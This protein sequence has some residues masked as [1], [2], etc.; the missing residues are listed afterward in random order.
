M[1]R[2]PRKMA[3]SWSPSFAYV[4]GIITADG[5][6]SPSGRH[7]NVVS[8]DKEIVEICKKTL[9]ISNKIGRKSRGGS[10]VKKYYVLQFGSV[11]FYQFLLKIGLM[12]AKSRIL[13][14]ISVPRKYFSDFLRGYM[15]G[16]GSINVFNHP[17]SSLPQLRLTFASGSLV[18]LI[19]L[20]TIIA[21]RLKISG[22][23]IYTDKRKN[24]Y[25]LCYAKRDARKIFRSVYYDSGCVKLRRKFIVAQKYMGE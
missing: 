10:D 25:I 23:W 16:D 5:N 20:K 9:E 3:T 8:K 15:D 22:G 13:R 17:E 19:W 12:P 18:F 24:V 2:T 4:I 14:A 11:V 1:A 21:K 6:L 7:I